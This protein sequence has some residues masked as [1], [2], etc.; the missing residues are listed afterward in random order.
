MADEKNLPNQPQ[1]AYR[2]GHH[3][4]F[5]AHMLARLPH[6]RVVDNEGSEHQPL[7]TLTTRQPDDPAVALLDAWAAVADVLSFYSERI[8]NEGYLPTASERRSVLELARAIGYELNPGVAASAHLAFTLESAPGSAPQTLIPARTPVQSLPQHGG[9]PQTFE[10]IAD[11]VAHVDWN[12]L[13][14]RQ[15]RPQSLAIYRGDLV[16]VDR[17]NALGPGAQT[18]PAHELNRLYMVNG[19]PPTAGPVAWVPASSLLL[20]GTANQ[21]APGRTLLLVGINGNGTVRTQLRRVVRM[22]RDGKR[23]RLALDGA[24]TPPPA[25]VPDLT[26]V[27][28]LPAQTA[29]LDAATAEALILSRT[30][31]EAD[32]AALR[33]QNGW[34][35]EALLA[36]CN[37]P[38]A[39]DGAAERRGVYFFRERVGTFGVSAPPWEEAETNRELLRLGLADLQGINTRAAA[40][41]SASTATAKT[42]TLATATRPNYDAGG[43]WSIWKTYPSGRYYSQD[44]ASDLFLEREVEDLSPQ[45]WIVVERAGNYLPLRVSSVEQATSLG[46]GLS[47][48]TSGLALLTA[49]DAALTPSFKNS[50]NGYTMRNS[51]V[52]VRSEKL[53]LAPLPLEM[54]VAAGALSVMLDRMTLDLVGGQPVILSGDRA[55]A[56]GISGREVA[57]VDTVLHR[58]GYTVLLLQSPLRYSYQRETLHIHANV[59]VASHGETQTA[60]LGSGNGVQRNQSFKLL[61]T[62]LTYI[63]AESES[64]AA[65]T[66]EVRVNGVRWTEAPTLYQLGPDEEGYIVRHNNDGSATVIFGDGEQGARLLSGQENVT[67]VY[68]AGIGLAGQV[69]AETLTLLARRPPGVRSVTNPIAASGAADPERLDS[70]RQN[71]PQRV[72]TL[73][74]VVSL[75]DYED[76]ARSFAGVGKARA[77]ALWRAGRQIVYLTVAAADGSTV[78]TDSVLHQ[79]LTKALRLAQNPDQHVE[80]AGYTPLL[81]TVAAHLYTDARY[82]AEDVATAACA[83][84]LDTFSFA[85]RRFG[86]DVSAAEVL[87]TLQ[88]VAGVVYVDLDALAL[89]EATSGTLP[90][91]ILRAELARWDATQETILPAQLLLVNPAALHLTVTEASP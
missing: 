12:A 20:E 17:E 8:A 56:P 23:T 66:L 79:N 29:T 53:A 74:R 24:E 50:H 27:D 9:L 73:G 60:V 10:T 61:R 34:N 22:E 38:T 49:E 89:G 88:A 70:A 82:R 16:Y 81:F 85:R 18:V 41:T 59:V 35:R 11:F 91:A 19:E 5:L 58:R 44:T 55:D 31:R 25:F 28:P 40:V 77:Q 67:A 26:M 4:D 83:A 33:T 52:H 75:Q 69:A 68:R 54:P 62:P 13:P 21:L 45:S 63:S 86:Q 37:H 80:V 48:K 76:F 15:T 47:G 84:L 2:L 43:G 72:R 90:T 46:F 7:R 65:S 3:A 71:A 57:T 39:E 32:V 87:A 36:L 14:P 30:V 42:T 1:L 64:G 6:Q 78:G 51:R